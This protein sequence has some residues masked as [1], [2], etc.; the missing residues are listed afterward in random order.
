MVD[1]LLIGAGGFAREAAEAVRAINAVTSR[2]RLLGFLDDDRSL[3][4]TRRGGLPVL[5]PIDAIR[6]HPAARLIICSG[7]PDNYVS[8]RRIADRL[9]LAEDRY[10]TVVHPTASVG[11]TCAIGRGSVVMAHA[12]LTA[13]VEV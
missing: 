4:G 9:R 7:R 6:D 3:Q 5:G 13:D 10:A 8:R 11:S 12:C 1:L 2:W